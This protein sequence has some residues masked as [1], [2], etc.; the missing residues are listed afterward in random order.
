MLRKCYLSYSAD[1]L[2]T[3]VHLI[4]FYPALTNGKG[5]PSLSPLLPLHPFVSRLKWLL[6]YTPPVIIAAHYRSI[7]SLPPPV[8][9]LFPSTFPLGGCDTTVAEL[10]NYNIR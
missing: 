3:R 1:S 4:Q 10:L 7:G 9:P 2:Q 5:F 6:V 8:H